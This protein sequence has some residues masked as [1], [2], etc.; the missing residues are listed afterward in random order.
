MDLLLFTNKSASRKRVA[1]VLLPLVLLVTVLA[2]CGSSGSDPTEPVDGSQLDLPANDQPDDTVQTAP[3]GA[4]VETGA[5]G[6]QGGMQNPDASRPETVPQPSPIVAGLELPNLPTPSLTP[7]PGPDSEPLRTDSQFNTTREFFLVHDPY[8]TRELVDTS[9]ALTDADFEAGPLPAVIQT[10]EHVDPASN[11]PPYFVDLFNVEAFAGETMNVRFKPVD[12]DGNVPGMFPYGVPVGAQFVDNFDGSKSLIWRPLQPDVGIHE[13]TVTATDPVEPFY[14]TIR[15][16][17]IK[18]VMPPDV[19]SIVNLSPGINQIRDTTVRVNDPVVAYIK[20]T[21]PNGTIPRLEVVNPPPGATITPHYKEPDFSI[22]RFVPDAPGLITIDLL[23][24]D[25]IDSNLTARS[26]FTVD[27]RDAADFTRPGARLREL[28]SGRDLLFGYAAIRNFYEFPDGA[29]YT[30]LAGEEFNLV[31]SETAMK[32]DRLNPL[33]GK[34]RWAAADNLVR[35]ARSRQQSIHGHTLVWHRQLPQ[36][37]KRSAPED[38]QIHMREFIDRVMQRYREDVT[39]WDVVNESLEED[40]SFRNSVW[41]EAMGPS[42]IDIAFRQARQSAPTATLLYNEYDVA[43][44]G[45]KSTAMIELMQTLKDAGTPI[46]GVGF[47][48]HV[49]AD[50][51]RFDEVEDRFQAIANLDLDVY[52]TELDVS[53]HADST[54]EQQADVYARILSA[55]LNQPR[56]KAFQS[57]GFTDMYSWRR[58]HKPLIFDD[59]YQFK[60]AYTSLQERLRQ[61]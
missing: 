32:W 36:W 45:P 42:Y 60:P 24:R 10:P 40:G 23:A 8:T 39:I 34:Y 37:I 21:D 12:P 43:F 49:F 57:W 3:P 55:C 46:D 44:K 54:L 27:V 2:G 28:A 38:R 25:A 53:L 51:D 17:R 59:S 16:I 41:F 11:A 7:A 20:V 4:L 13:F 35:F 56:C 52:I 29:L 9:H 14:R 48:L 58:E 33:P 19:D 50:F 6:G 22:L 26:S 47:Q 31:T 5:D 61:N 18:V 30:D 1:P 15:T